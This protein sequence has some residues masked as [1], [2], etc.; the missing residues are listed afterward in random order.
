VPTDDTHGQRQYKSS[1]FA[2][3]FNNEHRLIEAYN[4]LSGEHYPKDTRIGFETLAN[5][6]YMGGYNDIAF[7]IEG[8]YVILVEHQST[9]SNNLPLRLLLYLARI[10]EKMV[11]SDELYHR[12]LYR[13]PTPE[14]IVVY[15]GREPYPDRQVLR[16]S[17]AFIAQEKSPALELVATVY[18]VAEGH[19]AEVLAKSRALSDYSVFVSMVENY[20]RSGLPLDEAITKAIQECKKQGIMEAYLESRGSEVLNM[21]LTEWNWDDALRVR[22]E[23]EREIGEE[24]GE[25][26]GEAKLV[27]KMASRG[28]N[29]AHIAHETGLALEYV[30]KIVAAQN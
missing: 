14:F 12:K 6:L 24:I 28:R 10:Y 17:D 3:Y 7:T 30:E 16:L 22:G 25:K 27:R 19:N 20:R 23:E 4:A 9:L 21:L 11:P 1:L 13:I 29:A 18:N 15:N 5:V 26:R 2:D 8:R